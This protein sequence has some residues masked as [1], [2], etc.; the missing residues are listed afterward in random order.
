MGVCVFGVGF[1]EGALQ[2]GHAEGALQLDPVQP[3]PGLQLGHAEGA[4]QLDPLQP[5]LAFILD[6]G[7]VHLF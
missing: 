4:L 3:V 7:H 5:G 2:L 1:T 6:L